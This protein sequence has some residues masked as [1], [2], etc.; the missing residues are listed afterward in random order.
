MDNKRNQKFFTPKY[1][2]LQLFLLLFALLAKLPAKLRFKLGNLLGIM[3]G[4][5]AKSRRQVAVTNISRCFPELNEEQQ[6]GLVN[7]NMKATGQG[8][9]EAASCWFS[10]LVAQKENAHIIGKEH[11]DAALDEGKG[12]ILLGFHLTSLE[13]GS[14]ILGKY[15]PLYGMYKPNKN[16]LLDKVI[17][18]GRMRHFK[19]LINRNDLRGMVK[20]LKN[21]QIIW[22][23]TDQNYS[24]KKHVF[25]PFFGIQ[26]AT[27]NATSKLCKLTGA[28]VIPFTQ[29]RLSEPDCYELQ[30]YPALQN[31]PSHC[32]IKDATL[33]NIFLE[34]YLKENPEDY[35][36]LHHRFRTRPSGEKPFY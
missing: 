29:K 4:Y 26:T 6:N 2:L 33:I 27:I 23:A 21:N 8:L 3:L 1:W 11:L 20:G 19:G 34:N 12:V 14:G 32:D 18:K 10:D 13:V 30:L 5:M 7:N 15:Y 28:T 9:I 24:G 16:K 35:M 25:A 36:W 22:Y 31:F 17:F